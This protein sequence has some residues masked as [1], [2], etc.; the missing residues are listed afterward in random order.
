M[1]RSHYQRVSLANTRVRVRVNDDNVGGVC[2]SHYQR[3]HGKQLSLANTVHK[4]IADRE[5]KSVTLLTYLLT[6]MR[7]PV[8]TNEYLSLSLCRCLGDPLR[9]SFPDSLLKC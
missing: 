7:P 2:R 3:V 5:L 4:M 1:C 9:Q 6:S 8:L